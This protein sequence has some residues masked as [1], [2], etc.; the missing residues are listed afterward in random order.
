MFLQASEIPDI[1]LIW[2]TTHRKGLL[3]G[4]CPLWPLM[5]VDEAMTG[6]LR[7]F[8]LPP[9][10]VATPVL[11]VT[12]RSHFRYSDCQPYKF[13]N[14]SQNPR[15]QP[16]ICIFLHLYHIFLVRLPAYYVF[17][18][19]VLPTDF[20]DGCGRSFTFNHHNLK[21]SYD[22][23]VPFLCSSTLG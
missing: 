3:I 2:S 13:Q 15:C 11:T 8:S 17:G 16:A 23:R 21:E 20:L 18:S 1:V 7:P 12:R 6:P 4:K 19:R 9:L 10:L 5:R 22:A 14:H